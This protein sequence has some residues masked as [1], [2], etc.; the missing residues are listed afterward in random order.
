MDQKRGAGQ[1][2]DLKQTGMEANIRTT[3]GDLLSL[4]GPT[5]QCPANKF[6]RIFD[7]P[8]FIQTSDGVFYQAES[9]GNEAKGIVKIRYD[10]QNVF[11]AAKKWLLA[12]LR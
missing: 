8:V 3:G 2:L 11:Y 1:R 7:C 10:L 9:P 12:K 5:I 6:H 4:R